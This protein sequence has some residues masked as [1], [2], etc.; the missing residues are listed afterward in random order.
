MENLSKRYL[1]EEVVEG[2]VAKVSVKIIRDIK[3]DFYLSVGAAGSSQEAINDSRLLL[4]PTSCKEI[5]RALRGLRCAYQF[6]DSVGS[7]N[8]DISGAA[9]AIQKIA[10]FAQWQ[11]LFL[12]SL[13]VNPLIIGKTGHGAWAVD[14]KIRIKGFNFLDLFE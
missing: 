6:Q 2:G 3:H 5:T 10:H 14:A 12:S 13:E 4:L 1:I 9:K 11:N 8:A 7:V